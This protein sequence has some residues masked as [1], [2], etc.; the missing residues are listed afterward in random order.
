[1]NKQEW[2]A[3]S[4]EYG[5]DGFEIT[6]ETN[7]DRELTWFDG[8]VDSFVT[9]KVTKTSMRALYDNKIVSISM[10]KVDDADMD[11]IFKKLIEQAKVVS[12]TEKDELVPVIACDEVLSLRT[13]VRPSMEHVEKVLASLEQKFMA[14]PNVAMV[15]EL[16]WEDCISSKNM[17]NSLGLKVSDSVQYQLIMA[18][19]TMNEGEEI[20]D[21]YD[22]AIV[23]DLG[24]FDEDA[25]VKKLTDKVR[26]E[27]GARSLSSRT[28]PVIFSNEAMTTLFGCF[29]S[30]FYGSTIS[31]EISPLTGKLGE[32]IFSDK[33]TVIDNPRSQDAL[34]LQNYDDEGHPTYEKIVVNKGVF[35]TILH[36]TKS[37]LKMGAESTGNGFAKGAGATDVSAM[38]IF[39]VP[40]RD[41]LEQLQEK[42]G[43]GV[44]ITELNGMHAGVDFVSGNFSLQARGYLVEDGKKTRPLTLITVA[45]NYFDLMKDVEAVGNDLDWSYKSVACPAI[46]FREAA[47]SGQ[48]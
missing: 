1:M 19:I 27:L 3:K 41:S 32:K 22:I 20:R 35:D 39:I 33:I 43:N 26:Y 44:V 21:G 40:G 24:E 38:N 46:L 7:Q 16:Q 17:S 11:K 25:F 14:Q 30:A 13:W 28:C 36:N 2:I 4:K 6:E 18:Q 12:A 37:A 15:N 9:S 23:P 10:E 31:K 45:G 34:T 47:V 42:M 8:T 48:E 5:L 29:V